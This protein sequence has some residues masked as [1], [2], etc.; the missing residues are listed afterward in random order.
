MEFT[1]ITTEDYLKIH[2]V[3]AL[4]EELKAEIINM[5]D[6][7]EHIP[8][9]QFDMLVQQGVLKRTQKLRKKRTMY[10][11]PNGRVNYFNFYNSRIEYLAYFPQD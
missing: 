4:S 1:P 3:E 11:C 2:Y 6:N 10:V 8:Q 7:W 9:D 5:R